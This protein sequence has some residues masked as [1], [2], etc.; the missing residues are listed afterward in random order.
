MLFSIRDQFETLRI[1]FEALE[2]KVNGG[3]RRG[4]RFREHDRLRSFAVGIGVGWCGD[5]LFILV[6]FVENIC[7]DLSFGIYRS[8]RN[9]DISKV[10]SF[11]TIPY[12]TA[13]EPLDTPDQATTVRQ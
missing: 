5:W 7:G 11:Y 3:E 4:F 12:H 9:M 13:N 10:C 1:V 6:V 8:L 2:I